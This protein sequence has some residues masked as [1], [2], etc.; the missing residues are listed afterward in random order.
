MTCSWETD[1]G[2]VLLAAQISK[3]LSVTPLQARFSQDRFLV[4]NPFS[5]GDELGVAYQFVVTGVTAGRRKCFIAVL[6]ALPL[7]RIVC[8]RSVCM[9][10]KLGCGFN[11]LLHN[12]GRAQPPTEQRV[13]LV[14]ETQAMSAKLYRFG[15]L[16]ARRPASLPAVQVAF[17]CCFTALLCTRIMMD[18][19]R[20][21]H[22]R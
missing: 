21:A 6:F 18:D 15:H 8:S 7:Q 22:L 1:R 10:H 11:A 17:L 3:M 5:P 4:K 9:R 13:Q 20:T 2:E 19:S 14:S 12:E 16:S